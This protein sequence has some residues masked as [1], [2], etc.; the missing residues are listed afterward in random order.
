V[1]T[2]LAIVQAV[3]RW[4]AISD[5]IVNCSNISL[6]LAEPP[7]YGQVFISVCVYIFIYF[8]MFITKYTYFCSVRKCMF[9]KD[10]YICKIHISLKLDSKISFIFTRYENAC[11][12]NTVHMLKF[13]IKIFFGRRWPSGS[14][15]WF[16]TTC[17][18]PL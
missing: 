17:H 1:Y 13:K 7:S 5:Y 18:S 3:T 4:L 9:I 11:L 12:W 10:M 16:R 15:S 6:D 14:G 8:R 2:F